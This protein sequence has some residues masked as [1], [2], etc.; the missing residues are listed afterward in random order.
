MHNLIVQTSSN[1]TFNVIDEDI[2]LIWKCI[3]LKQYLNP[4]M[5]VTDTIS[6]NDRGGVG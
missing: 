3:W 1:M 4:Y 2:K 5:L 6:G